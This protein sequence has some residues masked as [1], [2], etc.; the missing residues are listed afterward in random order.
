MNK[1]IITEQIIDNAEIIIQKNS[2]QKSLLKDLLNTHNLALL[3]FNNNSVIDS[4]TSNYI[5]NKNPAEIEAILNTITV[6]AGVDSEIADSLIS[7]LSNNLISKFYGLSV[8]VNIYI[9]DPVTKMS[10][11]IADILGHECIHTIQSFAVGREYF[12]N[13]CAVTPYTDDNIFELAAY[14]FGGDINYKN[15]PSLKEYV[16]VLTKNKNWWNFNC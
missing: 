1:V 16:Q 9:K 11:F 14:K 6:Y 3:I 5:K 15:F 2:L 8:G 7:K 4:N 13:Y 10:T 12:I